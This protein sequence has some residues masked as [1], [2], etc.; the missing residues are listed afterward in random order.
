LEG[1]EFD[2]P[3]GA[4][5]KPTDA[6]DS[7]CRLLRQRGERPSGNGTARMRGEFSSIYS[8][9]AHSIASSGGRATSAGSQDHCLSGLHARNQL[10]LGRRL[11]R[12]A[13]SRDI[14]LRRVFR[15]QNE[16]RPHAKRNVG[17]ENGGKVE[18][19]AFFGHGGAYFKRTLRR[20]LYWRFVEE[21]I[22]P[23]LRLG[24]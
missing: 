13:D 7:L 19:G 5:I 11:Y 23:P 1:H 14:A 9:A 6:V 17:D 16:Y 8:I 24:S 4:N 21:S 2:T 3:S 20:R 22:A 15:H 18:L 10:R 12:L